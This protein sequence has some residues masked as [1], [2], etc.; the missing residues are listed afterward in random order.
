MYVTTKDII[1]TCY[2]IWFIP[3]QESYGGSKSLEDIKEQK[4]DGELDL[5]GISDEEIEQVEREYT[6]C[7]LFNEMNE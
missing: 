1:Y 4:D 6:F 3:E 2:D 7:Q 5:E